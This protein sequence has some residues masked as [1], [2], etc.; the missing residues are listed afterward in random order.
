MKKKK[1]YKKDK[2]NTNF[3]NDFDVL[4]DDLNMQ[5]E[6]LLKIEKNVDSE[7]LSKINNIRQ[8]TITV[9]R[10]AYDKI[11]ELRNNSHDAEEINKG[12]MI[13]RTKSRELYYEALDRID[14]LLEGQLDSGRD[15]LKQELINEKNEINEYYENSDR[16]R[17]S[18]KKNT[19]H[20]ES[21]A[22]NTLKSWLITEDK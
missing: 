4:L 11:S 2:K 17:N 6:S 3:N 5:Y 1:N 14:E 21:D 9:L 12:I 22:K 18:R 19:T 7:T 20:I 8:K 10:N 15:Y 13:V 16:K